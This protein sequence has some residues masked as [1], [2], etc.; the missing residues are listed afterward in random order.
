[1]ALDAEEKVINRQLLD[2][3]EQEST[4]E[5][6][7]SFFFYYK[8]SW[9]IYDPS[10]YIPGWHFKAIAEHLEALAKKQIM[11]LMINIPPRHSKPLAKRELVLTPKGYVTHGDLKVGDSVYHPS[12]KAIL[13]KEVHPNV[14]VDYQVTFSNNETIRCGE[15]HLWEVCDSLSQSYKIVETQNLK[16]LNDKTPG[17]YLL[18]NIS[19]L[20]NEEASLPIDPY[21]LGLGLRGETRI[22]DIYKRG[23][24]DQRLQLIE[25]L[26]KGNQGRPSQQLIEDITDVLISLGQRPSLVDF[27]FP[28][29]EI[30][31][32]RISIRTI[33]KVS[34]V[35]GNCI[36]VDS[37][38]GLY[39]VG[40]SAIPTHNSSMCNVAFPTWVWGPLGMPEV[41]FLTASY[42]KELALRDSVRSRSLIQSPWYQGQWGDRFEFSG[43]VNQ[44]SRYENQSG[45]KR[46]AT[47]IGGVGTGEG[48]DI[49][50][51]DD[52]HKAGE[53]NSKPKREAVLDWW[54]QTV[55]TRANSLDSRKILIMQ[56]LHQE[57]LAGFILQEEGLDNW[58]HLNL[59]MEYE[60]TRYITRIGWEDPR[61]KKGEILWPE[62]F[63]PDILI[64]LKKQ[65][66]EWGV[67]GQLQQRPVPLG[68]GI[69]K[70]KWFKY[71]NDIY[72]PY[73]IRG[74]FDFTLTSWDLSFGSRE[75]SFCVGQVWG[76]KS[77]TL[78]Y[79]LLDQVRGQFNTVDQLEAIKR[80]AKKH[81][82]CSTILVENRANGSA[83]IDLLR[84]EVPNLL[85][86]N[87]REIG[88][89]D[90]TVRAM[91]TTFLF[92]AG[93][94]VFPS[95][96]L[97]DKD[98]IVDFEHEV[99]FFPRGKYNDQVDAMTQAL[100]Y[101][102]TKQ[103]FRQVFTGSLYTQDLSIENYDTEKTLRPEGNLRVKELRELFS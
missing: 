81:P 43:D 32:E 13:V 17:R 66:G 44:K 48:Y 72:T 31:Q 33:E 76:R 27:S 56:R 18:R 74:V 93:R 77:K 36:T 70:D 63:P 14:N 61:T 9:D 87:P 79:Y 12:G 62:R 5:C 8:S 90:K 98:W 16:I 10:P 75:G 38:D 89:G 94:V 78:D 22:P 54:Q 60:P 88:G 2:S 34:P 35:L 71:Y 85:P 84:R 83:V 11:N 47:S 99:S 57:D 50:I 20:E 64:P 67:A 29:R 15:N 42:G 100:N 4:G 96:K 55:S 95:K 24:I 82:Y 1:M 19:P 46:L 51:I 7:R 86:V 103:S 80:L 21:S 68:G 58:T 25:G 102:E 41:Q 40:R 23:S 30:S 91:A 3:L 37:P 39:L 28:T 73:N 69:I 53:I 49:L 101:F 26:I 59:P 97:M 45:G 65:L 6:E 92:E 52:P